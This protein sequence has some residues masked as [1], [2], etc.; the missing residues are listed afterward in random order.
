MGR[1]RYTGYLSS[2]NRGYLA[3]FDLYWNVLDSR[4]ID[5]E[6]GAAAALDVYIQEFIE[7]NWILEAKPAFGFCFLRRGMLADGD[8]ALHH[9]RL[10]LMATPRDPADQR[11]QSF[12]PFK[13]Q[14]PKLP[15]VPLDTDTHL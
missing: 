1:N 6:I 3:C 8:P 12:D 9:A 10:L 15:D 14:A 4:R 7:W 13:N 2:T 5:P 11:L